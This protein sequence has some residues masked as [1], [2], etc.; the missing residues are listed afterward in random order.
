MSFWSSKVRFTS[1]LAVAARL[2][3]ESIS[4]TSVTM[5]SYVIGGT[6]FH[7]GALIL[8]T[9][10]GGWFTSLLD[11]GF[12]SSSES[13]RLGASVAP[14]RTTDRSSGVTPAL[15]PGEM[16]ARCGDLL[17]DES[18]A[19]SSLV[20]RFSRLFLLVGEDMIRFMQ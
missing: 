10:P 4:L 19:P 14:A 17:V 12:K 9:V 11:L 6:L 18:L 2:F 3:M 1:V 7:S 8:R 15:R 16:P 20:P 13:I 5:A